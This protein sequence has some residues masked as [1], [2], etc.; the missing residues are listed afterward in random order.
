MGRT[1]KKQP[2]RCS[3]LVLKKSN[4]VLYTSMAERSYLVYVSVFLVSVFCMVSSATGTAT[5]YPDLPLPSGVSVRPP[6][7][8]TFSSGSWIIDMGER[9]IEQWTTVNTT[10]R[11]FVPG[12][13]PTSPIDN[14]YFSSGYP[15]TSKRTGGTA[16]LFN[17]YAYGTL[18]NEEKRH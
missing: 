1:S 4:V 5:I 2:H 12:E 15:I 11:E 8:V 14:T 16:G 10:T 17:L 18:T 13:T 9:Q 6:N 3:A 7:W